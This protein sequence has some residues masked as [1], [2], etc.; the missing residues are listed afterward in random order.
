MGSP[1]TVELYQLVRPAGAYERRCSADVTRE[2]APYATRAN[3]SPTPVASA[4][5]RVATSDGVQKDYVIQEV[6]GLDAQGRWMRS[7]RHVS[8]MVTAGDRTPKGQGRV[9]SFGR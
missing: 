5:D 9:V 2:E 7:R 4:A 8:P 3:M 1:T 6:L